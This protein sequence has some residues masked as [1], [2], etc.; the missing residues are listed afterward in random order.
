MS[1]NIVPDYFRFRADFGL[2]F[3]FHLGELANAFGQ[4]SKAFGLDSMLTFDGR[5]KAGFTYAFRF[6]WEWYTLRFAG[7][8]DSVPSMGNGGRGTDNAIDFQF[9]VGWSL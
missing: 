8:I 9:L 6:I 4:D 3:P 7:P 5:I 1:Y 2:R